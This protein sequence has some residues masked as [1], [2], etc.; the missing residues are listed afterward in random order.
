MIIR[1]LC[2]YGNIV[3]YME[4]KLYVFLLKTSLFVT[5]DRPEK[6]KKSKFFGILDIMKSVF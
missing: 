1:V 3:S 4:A 2:K 5:F 6:M